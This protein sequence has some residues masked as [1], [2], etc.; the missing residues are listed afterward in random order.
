MNLIMQCGPSFPAAYITYYVTSATLSSPAVVFTQMRI[1]GFVSI[2]MPNNHMIAHNPKLFPLP[3]PPVKWSSVL[4]KSIPHAFTYLV[5]DLF[6]ISKPEISV[7][8]FSFL[9]G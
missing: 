1:Q 7:L 6:D 4:A 5:N 2:T 8:R 3:V 9:I